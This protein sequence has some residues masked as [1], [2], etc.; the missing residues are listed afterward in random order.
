[1]R[2]DCQR[3]AHRDHDSAPEVEQ[4]G[5]WE[6]ALTSLVPSELAPGVDA[7]ILALLD[8]TGEWRV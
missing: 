5:V 6:E 3:S 1:M 4:A 8:W 2:H 7:L